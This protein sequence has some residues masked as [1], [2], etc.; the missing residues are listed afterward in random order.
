MTVA[1][2]TDVESSGSDASD[3]AAIGEFAGVVAGELAAASSMAMAVLGDRLGLFE[4]LAVAGPVTSPELAARVGCAERYVREWLFSQAAGGWLRYDEDTERFELPRAHA[5]VLVDES[6]G[7]FMGA[8]IQL[9]DALYRSLD[10]LSET[11]QTGAG[12]GWDQHHPSLHQGVARFSRAFFPMMLPAWIEATGSPADRLRSGGRALDLGC[13]HGSLLVSL[14][15][16]FPTASVTGVDV[17]APSV[18]A[19][20]RNVADAGLSDQVSV[21]VADAAAASRV[22]E[23]PYDLVLLVDALHDMGDPVSVLAAA[24]R[25]LAPGGAVL[26]VEPMSSDCPAENFNPTGRYYYAI[27]TAFCMPSALSQSGGW[28]LGNQGGPARV[29]DICTKA[30]LHDVQAHE[31]TPFNMVFTA[32]P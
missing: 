19:A 5:A 18:D 27:S 25:V 8:S 28:A 22:A 7:A 17:H 13:G 26:I 4:A 24:R 1:E 20:R 31:P 30:G 2:G 6:S 12:T 10:R 3:A 15:R 11:F 21:H 14:A 29:V 32:R 23:G 16:A 9:L